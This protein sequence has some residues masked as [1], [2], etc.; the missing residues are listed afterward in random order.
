MPIIANPDLTQ[1][2]IELGDRLS[3]LSTTERQRLYFVSTG[4]DACRMILSIELSKWGEQIG[5]FFPGLDWD[6]YKESGRKNLQT[7]MAIIPDRHKVVEVY[8][9]ML[10]EAIDFI[11]RNTDNIAV[12]PSTLDAQA[13]LFR[14]NVALEEYIAEFRNRIYA[15]TVAT[16]RE[17]IVVPTDSS[18][19]TDPIDP[20]W[21]FVRACHVCQGDYN[22]RYEIGS[23]T[24][25]I[26]VV[27]NNAYSDATRGQL[28]K[29]QLDLYKPFNWAWEISRQLKALM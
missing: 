22:E 25:R 10:N 9:D 28:Y 6:I 12:V 4:T 13:R 26:R 3:A 27:Y 1:K 14:F 24:R 21:T 29:N 7:T 18:F 19:Q 16:E 15:H 23:I 8:V 5:T 20:G 11:Q 17:I 2:V